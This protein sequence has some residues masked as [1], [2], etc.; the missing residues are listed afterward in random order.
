MCKKIKKFVVL[1]SVVVCVMGL[2]F[3]A[4]AAYDNQDW[5]VSAYNPGNITKNC[6]VPMYVSTKNYSWVVSSVTPG[7]Y[8]TVRL[9]G[10]NC[11]IIML[12]NVSNYMTAVGTKYFKVS[13]VQT[14]ST[15]PY[16]ILGIELTYENYVTYYGGKMKI[17]Q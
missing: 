3:D 10:S 11:D 5:H 1:L 9:F 12:N 4:F 14:T 8:S 15:N 13:N 16:A 6:Y 7:S 17:V 2:N